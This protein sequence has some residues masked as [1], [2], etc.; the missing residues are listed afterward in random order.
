MQA[1]VQGLP[2]GE[3]HEADASAGEQQQQQGSQQNGYA[4]AGGA[5][6]PPLPLQ[7]WPDGSP[8][9]EAAIS[10]AA[11]EAWVRPPQPLN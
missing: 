2:G 11:E 7:Q 9:A 5:A 6:V 3:Q 10:R 8:A 4:G 1:C